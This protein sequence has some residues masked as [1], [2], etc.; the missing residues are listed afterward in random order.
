MR[1]AGIGEPS[2]TVTA[3]FGGSN[4][5]ELDED[6]EIYT[7]ARHRLLFFGRQQFEAEKPEKTFRIFALGGST[8]HGRPYENGSAFLKWMGIELSGRD[9]TR[10]YETVN[11]GGLSY[12]SYRLVTMLKEVLHYDPDLIVVATGHNEFLEDRSYEA[13]KK[14]ICLA[15]LGRPGRRPPARC[16]GRSPASPQIPGR[17]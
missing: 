13:E 10:D 17:R 4:L 15:S 11:C 2:D 5:F 6:E 16:D 12:A 8:V 7:T 14:P 3:G 9:S 1:I